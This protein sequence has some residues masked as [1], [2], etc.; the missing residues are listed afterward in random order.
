MVRT[1]DVLTRG[2]CD[3]LL[4]G[5]E[6]GRVGLSLGALPT[7]VAVPYRYEGD[8]VVIP[9]DKEPELA[10]ALD[11]NVVCFEIDG[12]DPVT[13]AQWSVV[14]VGRAARHDAL[15]PANGRA[16]PHWRHEIAIPL[17]RVTGRVWRAAAALS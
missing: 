9:V 7:I 17:E 1:E 10:A 14:A 2:Q 13:A 8:S 3:E 16:R 12:I 4:A 15:R 6:T 5:T 11:R